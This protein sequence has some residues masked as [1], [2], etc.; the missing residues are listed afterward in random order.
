MKNKHAVALGRLGGLRGGPAR[1]RALSPERRSEIA[2]AAVLTRWKK[3]PLDMRVRADR[4]AMARRLVG[5]GSGDV[6]TVEQVL[7]MQTLPPWERLARGR[8]R[9]RLGK[10]EGRTTC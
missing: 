3:P 2:R 9:S 1:A 8:R 7:F 5:A 6:G 4:R 10:N